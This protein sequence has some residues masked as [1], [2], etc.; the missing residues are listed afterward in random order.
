M[1]RRI[2]IVLLAIVLT[3]TLWLDLNRLT[4]YKNLTLFKRAVAHYQAGEF[5]AALEDFSSISV[6]TGDPLLLHRILF[7][8]GNCLARLGELNETSDPAAADQFYRTALD[9][10]REAG[11][12]LPGDRDS[13]SNQAAI[14]AARTALQTSL[15]K[16]HAKTSRMPTKQFDNSAIGTKAGE[17]IPG[18]KAERSAK[19]GGP[20]I[21]DYRDGSSNKRNT[22]G[23]E[24]AERLL[25]EK[26][27]EE[28]LPSAVKA[29]P[30]GTTPAPP[31][32]DW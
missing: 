13:E 31:A 12:L 16:Q 5:N 30:G 22:M 27:G 25:N 8:Q 18:N 29:T 17:K 14:K 19:Q 11:L 24:Q 2:I 28:T 4:A 21:T 26:R 10:Y 3:V 20:P 32:K 9:R 1:S 6:K 23:R 7:N 15:N